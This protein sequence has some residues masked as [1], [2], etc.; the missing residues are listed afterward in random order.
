MLVHGMRLVVLS[1]ILLLMFW[2]HQRLLAI[3]RSAGLEAL[4]LETVQR[5]FPQADALGGADPLGGRL[6]LQGSTVLGSVIQTFPEAESFLGFSGPTNLLIGLNPQ[7]QIQGMSILSTRDTEDHVDL[8]RRSERFFSSLNGQELD[9][10]QTSQVDAVSG[11]TLT[12]LA[13]LQG[14]QA[15][16][17]RSTGSLKFPDDDTLDQARRLFPQA[18]SIMQDSSTPELWIVSDDRQQLLGWLLSN[19]PVAD[20]VIGYQGPTRALIGM[21]LDSRIVGLLV[22]QSFENEPYLSSVRDDTWFAQSLNGKS[23]DELAATPFEESG[24]EGVSGATM[25]SQAVAQGLLLAAGKL[26]KQRQR[27][28]EDQTRS[29]SMP[30]RVVSTLFL[31]VVGLVMAFTSLRRHHPF[32]RGYQ[33]ALIVI[34]GL[35][36]GDLLSM[37][38]FVGWAQNGIPWQNALALVCLAAAALILPVVARTNVYCDHLCPHGAVQQL[39]PRRWKLKRLPRWISQGLQ[40]IRPILLVIVVLVAMGFGTWSLVNLEP[41]DAYAWRAA[42][43]ATLAVAGIGLAAS[44]LVPMGYCQ[45]GC[46]TGAVLGYLRRHSRSDRVSTAD[47]IAVALLLLSVVMAAR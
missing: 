24:I 34:M 37:A 11:A 32:R 7:Q 6:V 12:S 47:G 44:L 46:P 10:I 16:L 35:I 13:I 42:G 5:L 40:W 38:M 9:S 4:P 31:V 14:I 8:I 20:N 39:L 22:D 36:N 43:T 3:Q 29:R 26:V 1:V 33:I 15:R 19:S 17:G 45:Y 2:Q 23:V 30:L 21:G 27:Q 18:A 28:A 25:T 41:F